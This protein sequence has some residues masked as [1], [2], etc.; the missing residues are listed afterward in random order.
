MADPWAEFRSAAPAATDPWA[1]FRN[2]GASSVENG[3]VNTV[4]VN[5][6]SVGEDVAKSFGI[7]AAKGAIGTTM[8]GG[9][10]RELLSAGVDYAA[11]RM[12]IDP[13]RVQEFK[14]L[15]QQGAQF[16]PNPLMQAIAT[17]PTSAQT[18][19]K[20]EEYTGEFYKPQT[21]AGEY[22]Q[23]VGEFLPA[24]LGGEA[25]LL[26]RGARVAVP[27]LAS[28]TAGQA[29]EGTK[30]EPVARFGAALAGG[31]G[32]ALATRPGTAARALRGQLPP[33]VTEQMVSDAEMLIHDAA[34]RGVRLAWPE[35]LSQVA[36]RPVLTNTMRHLEASPQTEARMGQFFAGRPQQVERTVR[37]ELDNIAPANPNPSTIGREVGR[38]AEGEVTMTR[39]AINAASEPFYDRSSTILLTPQEMTRV[40]AI[41]G[42]E[43]ARQAVRGDPQL[44]RYVEHLPD[45]SVGFLNE[46]KKYLD[47]AAENARGQFN[48]QRNQQRA[49]GYENDANTTRRM[50]SLVDQIRGGGD[51]QRALDIQQRGREQILQPLLDGYIGKLAQQDQTTQQA[52]NTLFPRNPLPNS[53]QEIHR[54]VQALNRH[55]PRASSD[56]VRAHAEMTF[57]EAARDLQTGPNAA[58]GAKF[59]AAIMGNPQQAA[60]LE[61]A[62]TALPHGAQR[63]EGFNRLMDILEATGTRQNV[64]SRTAY[65]AE[66]NKAQSAGGV[67]RDVAKVGLNPMRALQP[68]VERYDQWKLGRNLNQLADILTD[69]AAGNQLRA[70]ARMPPG[71]SAATAIALRLVTYGGASQRALAPPVNESGNRQSN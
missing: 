25:S 61:A 29:T 10:I 55:N 58:N 66:I 31:V 59:R 4:T 69:P 21:T 27:A 54:A 41:P 65:N 1:D 52:I 37:D 62:V 9:D 35:A 67:A 15:V 50:A 68:L 19:K 11:S 34:Q 42:F 16:A 43:E 30:A 14:T 3:R 2:T 12:G 44:N 48:A 38:A 47:T 63:W 17:S 24:A 49:A 40:R 60:N 71:S 28:E 45:D 51:Y 56:L 39:G 5:R 8:A 22:A 6:P 46:V 18:Q 23:T 64:G 20:I 7:G 32:T 33:G 70:I 57:N 36:Q 13:A 26:A 53:E